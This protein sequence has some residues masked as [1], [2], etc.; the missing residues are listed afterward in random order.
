MSDE[1]CPKCGGE[2]LYTGLLYERRCANGSLFTARQGGG[3]TLCELSIGCKQAT[4]F[5]DLTA[6]LAAVEAERDAYRRDLE[7]SPSSGRLGPLPD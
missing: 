5:R 4:E 6:K 2:L 7:K 1:A 3:W